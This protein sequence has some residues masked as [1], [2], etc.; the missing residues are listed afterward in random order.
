MQGPSRDESAASTWPVYEPQTP[1]WV[2]QHGNHSLLRPHV[3]GADTFLNS[4][5]PPQ[6]EVVL[7]LCSGGACADAPA[8]LPPPPLPAAS[9]PEAGAATSGVPTAAIVAWVLTALFILSLVGLLWRRRA[10]LLQA[11]GAKPVSRG[12]DESHDTFTG[13]GFH[14]GSLTRQFKVRCPC[15]P[16]RQFLLTESMSCSALHEVVERLLIVYIARRYTHSAQGSA[17]AHHFPGVVPE[18]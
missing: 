11:M 7:E 3:H 18:N 6:V 5:D 14:T 4:T 8:L 12:L 1:D 15:P 13:T 10:D 17:N 16:S 2:A 9:P